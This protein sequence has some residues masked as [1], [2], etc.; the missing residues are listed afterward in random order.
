MVENVH[1][2]FLPITVRLFILNKG[3]SG[4]LLLSESSFS[5]QKLY[6][7]SEVLNTYNTLYPDAYAVGERPIAMVTTHP[8]SMVINPR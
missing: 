5:L 1:V 4:S 8:A 3:P 2:V 7:I 6:A